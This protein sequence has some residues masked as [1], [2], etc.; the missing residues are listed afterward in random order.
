MGMRLM[1]IIGCEAVI[2]RP[3][4]G[5]DALH[6]PVINKQV[7]DTVDRYAVD[8]ITAFQDKVNI[9]GG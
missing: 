6:K 1:M 4:P 8:G 5:T 2:K 7:E 9:S 3:A